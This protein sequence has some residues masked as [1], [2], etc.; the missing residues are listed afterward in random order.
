MLR[1]RNF[2]VVN[3]LIPIILLLSANFLSFIAFAQQSDSTKKPIQIL[4][5]AAY[6]AGGQI[7]NDTFLYNP[8]YKFD[9]SAYY[10]LSDAVILGAGTGFISLSKK[11][12]FIPV[13]ASF[14]GFIKP[15]K[16]GTCLMA[17]A[18][19]S[20]GWDVDVN[21]IQGY[22][23]RGGF[24]A[25]AGLGHRF[26]MKKSALMLALVYGHQ[27]AGAKFVNADGNLFKERLDFDW[28]GIELQFMFR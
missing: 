21:A 28:L 7:Y 11:E 1:K 2:V 15:K 5:G 4:V 8:G 20:V 10:N 27:E 18:G 24:M 13:Y 22:E 23:F 6:L 16:S 3:R 17:K 12:R 14:K 9:V 26:L 25:N 19:Y